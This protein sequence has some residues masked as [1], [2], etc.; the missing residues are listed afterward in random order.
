MRNTTDEL[1]AALLAVD[2]VRVAALLE[3][4]GVER[5]PH[6]TF[7]RLVVP[8]LLSIGE[9]WEHGR[10]ALAQVYMSGLICEELVD[11]HVP[12][13]SEQTTGPRVALAVLHDHHHLG[14]RIVHSVLRS[15]GVAV[16]DYGRVEAQDVV[17]RAVADDVQVLLL[18]VLMLPSAL[19]VREVVDRLPPGIRVGVGG[20]PF[21]LDPT[22]ADRVGAHGWGA[23]ATDVLR[24]VR[25]LAPDGDTP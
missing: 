11:R 5:D 18:S 15:A 14:R 13:A 1:E 8:A 21:R 3:A 2:R 25:E 20:A 9:S 7:E 16:L 6:G 19:R 23:T 10:A 17:D 24:L 12:P 22:L 4:A